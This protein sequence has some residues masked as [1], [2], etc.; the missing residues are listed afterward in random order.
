MVSLGPGEGTYG[1][2][3]IMR[4]LAALRACG[5]PCRYRIVGAAHRRDALWFARHQL[6][7]E[8]EV[9]F[10]DAAPDLSAHLRWADVVL[11]PGGDSEDDLVERLTAVHPRLEDLRHPLA[12]AAKENDPDHEHSNH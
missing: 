9:E 4:A 1:F 6:D 8:S 10:V 7:L 3:T 12:A 2:D 5:L 11:E